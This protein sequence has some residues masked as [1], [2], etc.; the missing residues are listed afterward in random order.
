[1]SEDTSAIY[2]TDKDIENF[3][4]KDHHILFTAK[5]FGF[6][7]KN[8]DDIQE[9]KFKA[10]MYALS[11][12]DRN[13]KFNGSK[14]LYYYMSQITRGA[15]S[16]TFRTRKR[17]SYIDIRFESDLIRPDTYASSS[18]HSELKPWLYDKNGVPRVGA[19]HVD[20]EYDD[21]I[22]YVHKVCE[23]VLSGKQKEILSL[24]LAGKSGSEIDR[25]MG[26]SNGTSL[27]SIARIT[28]LIK[29]VKD[30]EIIYSKK[31]REGFVFN[32]RENRW[33]KS[34]TKETL[35]QERRI[36]TSAFLNTTKKM[37]LDM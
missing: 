33:H 5:R 19:V 2:I 27:H 21:R 23:K 18:G 15:L 13:K 30:G 37:P 9:A 12:R 24:H 4:N 31:G 3:F 29:K 34:K 32:V 11:A 20:E 7:F 10:T 36:S 25:L 22:D 17:K 28:K 35:P 14:H 1:M 16:H 6:F 8:N 26:N